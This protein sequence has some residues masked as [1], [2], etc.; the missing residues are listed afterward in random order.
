MA[1]TI[2]PAGCQSGE[3][4]A[5][6]ASL[7]AHSGPPTLPDVPELDAPE[8]DLDHGGDRWFLDSNVGDRFPAWTRGNAADVFPDPLSP[9]AETFYMRPGLSA[10][11]RD[12]YISMGVLD[13]EEV[14]EPEHP[15]YFKLFGG[16]LYNPLSLTRLLGARMPG[17]T[18]EVIDQAFFDDRD[19]VPPYR[20]EPWHESERHAALLGAS[21]Q[22]ALCVT[23]FP[24]L[25]I[26]KEQAENVRDDRPDL[27]SLT[28]ALL[29]ARARS[30]VPVLQAMF[31]TGMIISS[32]SSLGPGALGAICAGLGDPSMTI[33]LLAGIDVD[34]AAPSH[35]MWALADEAR[36]SNELSVAFGAG[37][38]GLLDRLAAAGSPAA[39]AFLADFHEVVRRYGHAAPTSGTSSRRRGRC[40]RPPR[41][42]PSISCA[43]PPSSNPPAI[44]HEA[45]VAERDRVATDVRGPAGRRCRRP[46]RLRGRPGLCAAVPE[47]PRALQDELHHG[48]QRDPDGDARARPPP[49][50]TRRDRRRRA[51][52]HAHQR[53]AGRRPPAPRALP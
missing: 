7:T 48:R 39:D 18:P 23:A 2:T 45:S 24:D 41:S 1:T 53:R 22:W 43:A 49:H 51:G 25:D 10:G 38:D 28:D 34:S 47:R 17:V 50:R 14:E 31:E 29:I 40:S 46:R 35:A 11:L 36:A 20:A 13:W 8:T 52:L 16:Y 21:M 44:R 6:P 27:T 12:A 3:P 30:L 33:R 37:V 26:Q 5:A 32:L 9:L 4:W 15:D 42:P 19:E